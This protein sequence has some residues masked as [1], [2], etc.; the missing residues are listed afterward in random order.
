MFLSG[1]LSEQEATANLQ[2]INA[3]D[4]GVKPWRLSFSFGRALQQSCLKAWLGKPE[5]VKAGQDAFM[6]RAK[7]NWEASQGILKG[8]ALGDIAAERT[9]E[10][11]YVY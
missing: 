4:C 5:N 3:V 10:K 8:E 2:A 6:V 11:N 7:A 9:Y 1:G